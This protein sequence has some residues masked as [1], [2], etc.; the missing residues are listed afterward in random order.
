MD[1]N[2]LLFSYL[3]AAA[4][5]FSWLDSTMIFLAEYSIYILAL[6]VLVMLT[7]KPPVTIRNREMAIVALGSAI[8]ARAG[9]TEIVRWLYYH[10]RPYWALE[11]VNLLLGQNLNGSFPSGHTMFAF[12]LA[13]GVYLYDKRAGKWFYALAVVMGIARVFVGA[14]W[15]YDILGGI[16]LGVLTTLICQKIYTKHIKKHIEK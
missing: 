10:P 14:H 1:P 6:G 9:V 3:N 8:V 5:R 13:T 7:R 4:G 11:N 16:V 12:A 2:V 15:P